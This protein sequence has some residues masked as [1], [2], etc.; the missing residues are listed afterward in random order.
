MREGRIGSG[1]TGGAGCGTGRGTGRWMWAS[2]VRLG[3]RSGRGK[4]ISACPEGVVSYTYGEA[5]SVRW[6]CFF[7]APCLPPGIRRSQIGPSPSPSPCP[8]GRSSLLRCTKAGSPYA[9][10]SIAFACRRRRRTPATQPRA[11]AAR[12]ARRNPRPKRLSRTRQLTRPSTLWP[13][14]LACL[15]AR[16]CL[17]TTDSPSRR[18]LLSL[19][20]T[21][22]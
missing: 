1:K 3:G 4:R 5:A 6:V 2:G 8:V 15:E 7:L 16:P 21:K 20:L 9:K 14:F 19:A 17:A 22:P 12:S 10:P 13:C 18:S 11:T